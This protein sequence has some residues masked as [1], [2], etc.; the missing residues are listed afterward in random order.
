MECAFWTP[1]PVSKAAPGSVPVARDLQLRIELSGLGVE[2]FLSESAS[3]P[4][5]ADRTL[6]TESL[7][8]SP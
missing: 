7:Q 4:G 3:V 8:E 6:Q 2:E 1:S 5:A